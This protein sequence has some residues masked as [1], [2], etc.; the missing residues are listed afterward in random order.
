MVYAVRHEAET[1]LRV[2]DLA[3][4][5]DRWL[6]WPVQRDEVETGQALGQRAFMTGPGI[7][8]STDFQSYEQALD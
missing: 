4:G 8:S 5:D 2:R 3:T 6:L 7:L 1:G